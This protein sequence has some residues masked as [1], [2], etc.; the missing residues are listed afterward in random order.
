MNIISFGD[1]ACEKIR[2]YMDSY[3]SN[4]LLVETNHEV[5]RHLEACP[6]CSAEVEARSRVKTRL[7]AAVESQSVPVDLQVKIREQIRQP[8]SR[9]VVT[10]T[11]T[12]WA[13]A[14]AAA[15]VLT[16]GVWVTRTRTG[17]P[18]LADRQAQNAFIQRV[19]Q[20]VSTVLRVGLGDHIHCSVFRKYPK[21]APSLEQ[22]AESMGP[23][24]KGLVQLVKASVP[25]Q[26]RIIMAHQCGYGGRRFVHVTLSDGSKLISLVIA[27]KE[28][29][30]SMETLSPTVRRSGVA[31]YQAATDRYEVAGFE[32]K[33][34]LAFVVS[35]LSSTNN[36]QLASNLAPAVQAF[37][38]KA[39]S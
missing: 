26:Y 10:A 25:D 27:R 29:G 5:L 36:L 35:D 31:L 18:D 23:A 21:K 12:R 13:M 4:E 37:L 38:N 7:K 2:R 33:Q 30:E 17:L 34:Y 9:P 32:A 19:S 24:Y 39:Q 1:S 28:P 14:A 22:M 8:E 11:R 6:S 20:T 3:I 16:A 15:V